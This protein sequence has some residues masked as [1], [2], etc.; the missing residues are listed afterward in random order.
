MLKFFL[1][2]HATLLTSLDW[3]SLGMNAGTIYY[4]TMTSTK[5][6]FQVADKE[7]HTLIQLVYHVQI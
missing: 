4:N 7:L 1:W 2:A 5:H 3:Y 6:S